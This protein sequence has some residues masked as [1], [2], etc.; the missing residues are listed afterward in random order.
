[1]HQI[2]SA[3]VQSDFLL[4]GFIEGVVWGGQYFN[5][6]VQMFGTAAG[7][8][9]L[10][11]SERTDLFQ[12][13]PGL[14]ASNFGSAEIGVNFA[15]GEV[16]DILNNLGTNPDCLAINIVPEPASMALALTSLLGIFG[17]A[18]RKK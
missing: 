8:E 2:E 5:G 4:T 15:S 6:K 1:L 9:Y 18:R 12:L 14:D 10:I 3:G 7:N 16:G 13:S 11:P 17:L